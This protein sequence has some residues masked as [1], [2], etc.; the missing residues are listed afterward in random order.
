MQLTDE[1][2]VYERVRIVFVG[3]GNEMR[4][5]DAGG[6]VFIE[7]L[8]QRKEFFKSHFIIAGRNPENHLQSILDCNPQIVIFI[9]AAEWNGEPGEIKILNDN[10]ISHSEFSTHT[11]SIMMIKDFLLQNQQMDFMFLG[12]QPHITDLK[13]G[14]SDRVKAKINDFFLSNEN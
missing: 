12:I 13:E 2:A 6:L 10:E 3:L 8:R 11:F 7:M 5:D 14:L 9:D 1:L 4:G